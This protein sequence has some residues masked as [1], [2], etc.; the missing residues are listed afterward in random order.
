MEAMIVDIIRKKK[1][2]LEKEKHADTHKDLITSLLSVHENDSSLMMSIEEIT[3]NII[4]VMIGG[5]DTTSTL[6]SL[7]IKLLANNESIYRA[8]VQGNTSLF[9]SML[10]KLYFRT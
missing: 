6:V 5:Y 8:I 1:Q 9:T 3:D 10:S 7:F 4:L 2:T